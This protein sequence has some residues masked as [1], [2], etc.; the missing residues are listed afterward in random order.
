MVPLALWA[1]VSDVAKRTRRTAAASFPKKPTPRTPLPPVAI[2][3]DKLIKL[4]LESLTDGHVATLRALHACV[5]S[6]LFNGKQES[7]PLPTRWI[8]NGLRDF[9]RSVQT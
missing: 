5:Y 8:S 3:F 2:V 9:G 4:L 1:N 7:F 6:G